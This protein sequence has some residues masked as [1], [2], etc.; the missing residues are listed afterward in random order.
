MYRKFINETNTLAGSIFESEKLVYH[1]SNNASLD[2]KERPIKA[3][4]QSMGVWFSDS[5]DYAKMFGKNLHSFPVPRGKFLKP[6]D[7]RF[8]SVFFDKEIASKLYGKRIG[9]LLEKYAKAWPT[10][11]RR[12]SGWRE[13]DDAYID[14]GEF[15]ED[16]KTLGIHY[17][18]STSSAE[19]FRQLIYSN[20]DYVKLL[21]WKLDSKYDGIYF[22][23]SKI[24]ISK[25]HD[26]YLIFHP[27]KIQNWKK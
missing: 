15:V 2:L 24:D 17:K 26:V 1:A 18:G 14:D 19:P 5:T 9:S 6:K 12:A 25:P 11:P 13:E 3:D 10:S 23:N 27:N 21:K 20:A 7:H 4:F 16:L 22:K 8:A